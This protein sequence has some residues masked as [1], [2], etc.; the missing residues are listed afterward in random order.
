[1][2]NVLYYSLQ[3]QYNTVYHLYDIYGQKWGQLTCFWPWSLLI[4]KVLE[5]GNM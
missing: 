5:K 1:M 2:L 4:D 3:L